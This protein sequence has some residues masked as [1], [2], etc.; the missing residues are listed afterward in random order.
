MRKRIERKRKTKKDGKEKEKLQGSL[1]I[2]G[3]S[4]F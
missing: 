1:Q 2:E 3:K 4:L